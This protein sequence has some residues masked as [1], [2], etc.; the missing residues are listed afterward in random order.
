MRQW[1][2]SG[3]VE[4]V[5]FDFLTAGLIFFPGPNQVDAAGIY[6]DLLAGHD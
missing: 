3:Y 4:A 2:L 1:P 6:A 5:V